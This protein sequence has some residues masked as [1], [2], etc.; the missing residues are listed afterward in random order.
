MQ[1]NEHIIRT[2]LFI[3]QESQQ[4]VLFTSGVRNLAMADLCPGVN[5]GSSENRTY[6]KSLESLTSP[7]YDP[8]YLRY[9]SSS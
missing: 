2:L 5:L 4:N 9:G 8:P 7:P 6:L 1:F 3:D